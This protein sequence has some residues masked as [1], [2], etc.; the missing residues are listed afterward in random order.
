[1]AGSR[2]IVVQLPEGV[3]ATRE[4]IDRLQAIFD[5]IV[6]LRFTAGESG[7]E[8]CRTLAGEGWGVRTHLAWAAE[9]RKGSEC[10]QAIG[11]TRGEAL[12]HLL[13][14]VRADQVMSAP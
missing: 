13:R 7:D 11:A 1:M 4:E 12:E 14:L 8:A 3:D 10:E 2:A 5:A 9:A 6:S